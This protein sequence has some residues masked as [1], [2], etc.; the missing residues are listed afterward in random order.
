MEKSF[1]P[2]LSRYTSRRA[3]QSGQ[4]FAEFSITMI[5]LLVLILGLAFIAALSKGRLQSLLNS[6]QEA[7]QLALTA[8]PVGGSTLHGDS[9]TVSD[10]QSEVLSAADAPISYKDYANPSYNYIEKNLVKP[11]NESASLI[12]AF[13]LTRS[14]QTVIIT[15]STTL[16]NLKVGPDLIPITE[17]VT[18]P[19]LEGYD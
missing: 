5:G 6:R 17:S 18:F 8:T 19:I 12:D 4:A 3:A 7:G 9:T 15:N 2:F 13:S 1:R 10:M 16:K 14:E 11:I